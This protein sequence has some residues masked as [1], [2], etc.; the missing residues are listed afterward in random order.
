MMADPDRQVAPMRRPRPVTGPQ[1]R[2]VLRLWLYHQLE[3]PRTKAI[4]QESRPVC[5]IGS[6]DP[7]S[8]PKSVWMKRVSYAHHFS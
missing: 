4:T 1:E 3:N 7:T 2:R 8:V 6:I 5:K